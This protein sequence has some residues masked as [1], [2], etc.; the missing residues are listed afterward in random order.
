MNSNPLLK[1]ALNFGAMSGLGS[2][3]VFLLL[4]YNGVNPLGNATWVGA[5]IPIVFICIATK[6]YRD[7]FLAGEITYWQAVKT[8]MATAIAASFLYAFLIYIF[9]TLIDGNVVTAF[10]NEKLLDLEQTKFMFNE[11]FYEKMVDEID[12]FTIGTIA[13]NDFFMKII[14]SFL[15]SLIT[16]AIYRKQH[17]ELQG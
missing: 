4:Y 17:S 3:A 11:D 15:V 10:K 12:K 16:A 5:W 14:G 13:F 1:T 7:H 6:N 2:F 8:G 9:V